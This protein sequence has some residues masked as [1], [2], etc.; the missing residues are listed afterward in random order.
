MKTGTAIKWGLF[1]AALLLIG[2]KVKSAISTAQALTTSVDSVKFGRFNFPNLD[3]VVNVKV[4]NPTQNDATA[5][6][7]T[8]TITAPVDIRNNQTTAQQLGSFSVALNNANNSGIIVPANSNVVI[9]VDAQVNLLNTAFSLLQNG[10]RAVVNG[11]VIVSGLS[12]NFTN[13]ITINSNGI[14]VD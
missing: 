5:Q 6:S 12:L 9:G 13:N 7:I 14:N 11:N 2:S 3:M 8:G 10:L 4:T 1:G